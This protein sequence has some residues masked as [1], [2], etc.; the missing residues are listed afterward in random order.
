M[1]CDFD[2]HEKTIIFISRYAHSAVSLVKMHLRVMDFQLSALHFRG[3]CK[4]RKIRD[5]KNAES[6]KCIAQCIP[7]Q[8]RSFPAEIFPANSRRNTR[9]RFAQVPELIYRKCRHTTFSKRLYEVTI[10]AYGWRVTG[11]SNSIGKK[12]WRESGWKVQGSYVVSP[13]ASSSWYK[14]FYSPI[15]IVMYYTSR[16]NVIYVVIS[17]AFTQL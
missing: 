8:L 5:R 10:D 6:A 14:L 15:R 11:D 17:S 9:S 16:V 2:A 1:N 12:K 3:K 7:A 13:V 4:V